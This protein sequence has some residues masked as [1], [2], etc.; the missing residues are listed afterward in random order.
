MRTTNNENHFIILITVKACH[1]K[2][3]L[4]RKLNRRPNDVTFNLW[5]GEVWE[6]KVSWNDEAPLPRGIACATRSIR[7]P[8]NAGLM[9]DSSPPLPSLLD[10]WQPST[11]SFTILYHG[12]CYQFIPVHSKS[13]YCLGTCFVFLRMETPLFRIVRFGAVCTLISRQ[14]PP[15]IASGIF[16]IEAQASSCLSSTSHH[17]ISVSTSLLWNSQVKTEHLPPHFWD[18]LISST[19][20][21]PL[22][23]TVW[24]VG[25]TNLSF[26]AW[27]EECQL[28]SITLVDVRKHSELL[29]NV[30]VIFLSFFDGGN[31][32]TGSS[33][34]VRVLLLLAKCPTSALARPLAPLL[35]ALKWK[36][37]LVSRKLGRNE[38][39]ASLPLKILPFKRGGDLWKYLDVLNKLS[40]NGIVG[41]LPPFKVSISGESNTPFVCPR[42]QWPNSMQIWATQHSSTIPA[43]LHLCSTWR[44]TLFRLLFCG[45]LTQI[46]IVRHKTFN[47]FVR[48]NI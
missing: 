17:L 11:V 24:E 33:E 1:S 12:P 34:T 9:M 39:T 48:W 42:F 25:K 18:I 32:R 8:L 46:G 5:K 14:R 16:P 22:S 30:W 6:F 35:L 31:R 21:P 38:R 15:T 36:L 44:N 3:I 43:V 41:I 26:L 45:R 20:P 37:L 2:M 7:A 29:S 47:G 13:N 4:L 19:L 27:G 40:K 10:V 23:S 28:P